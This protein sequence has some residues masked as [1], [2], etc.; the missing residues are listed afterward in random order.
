MPIHYNKFITHK[1]NIDLFNIINIYHIN[2]SL[3]LNISLTELDVFN[4]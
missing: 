4:N 2:E 1:Y 3:L